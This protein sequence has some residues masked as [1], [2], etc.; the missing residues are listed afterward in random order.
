M[1]KRV[2]ELASMRAPN[3]SG[4]DTKAVLQAL[5]G[6]PQLAATPT[7]YAFGM[8]VEDAQRE[9]QLGAQAQR[10]REA[11]IQDARNTAL[12]QDQQMFDIAMKA[13]SQ[14]MA[15]RNLAVQ[16]RVAAAEIAMK[17]ARMAGIP[18]EI[19]ARR[20]AN[21]KLRGEIE[22]EK[23]M[24][25]LKIPI[26]NPNN[27]EQVFQVPARVAM[28]TGG[29]HLMSYLSGN[30]PNE[31]ASERAIRQKAK[32]YTDKGLPPED[33]YLMA[34]TNLANNFP[35]VDKA[36]AAEVKNKNPK[37]LG[38]KPD[39]GTKGVDKNGKPI[40]KTLEDFRNEIW[41]SKID[42]YFAPLSEA[43]RAWIKSQGP[44]AQG[45]LGQAQEE[46]FKSDVGTLSEQAMDAL[47]RAIMEG[48]R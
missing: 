11:S 27:P 15:E 26:R 25:D 45:F 14:Y 7:T 39:Y 35:L 46:P 24:D 20:L 48:Y 8:N 4:I 13:H 29:K 44:G 41:Q 17:Q 9:G 40:P 5:A 42:T 1:E 18:A 31:T 10:Q 30:N 6:N 37:H 16:E 3:M 33:A 2:E 12:Q 38:M 47:T 28:T 32:I 23:Q 22:F 19:E 34:A 43:G 21:E 36:V